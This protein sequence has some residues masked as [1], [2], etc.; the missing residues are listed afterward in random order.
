MQ[1]ITVRVRIDD[2]L[3][4]RFKIKAAELQKSTEKLAAEVIEAYLSSLD[5]RKR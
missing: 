2:Y 3:W 4:H 1:T 5:K